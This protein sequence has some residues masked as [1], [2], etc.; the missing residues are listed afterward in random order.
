M[1]NFGAEATFT[2]IIETLGTVTGRGSGALVVRPKRPFKRP[3][4][5]ESVSVNGCCLT[6]DRIG[7]VPERDSPQRR[8]VSPFRT[9]PWEIAFRLLPETVRVSTLGDLRVGDPVN[10]E[11][12]LRL[13]DRLGG[14]LMLGHVDGRGTVVARSKRGRNWTLEIK[15]PSAL[16]GF[17]VPKGPIGLDGVSLTLDPI[18]QKGRIKVHLIPHT[19]RATTL[20]GKPVGSRVNVEVDLIAKLLRGMLY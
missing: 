15:I 6:V 4:R 13:G 11:R 8:R 16:T 2:G 18:I 14:H 17:L 1:F 9:S 3:S 12:S 20:G 5:G 10:L 7:D 19:A